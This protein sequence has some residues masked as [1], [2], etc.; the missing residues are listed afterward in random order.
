MEI[1]ENFLRLD[2][3]LRTPCPFRWFAQVIRLDR[4]FK[5][6]QITLRYDWLQVFL[7][8]LLWAGHSLISISS[9]VVALSVVLNSALPAIFN[10]YRNI[11]WV[12]RELYGK[13]DL[14]SWK[15]LGFHLD[16]RDVLVVEHIV[17]IQEL[18][19]GV[20]IVFRLFEQHML[21][22]HVVKLGHLF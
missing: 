17:L 9:S 20:I 4:A 3:W 2:L 21:Q 1:I 18:V 7:R 13:R 5:S 15:H 10:R 14:I 16:V 6:A 22:V 19:V 11:F 8:Q 12:C